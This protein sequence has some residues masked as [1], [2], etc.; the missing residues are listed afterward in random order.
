MKLLLPVISAACA[1]SLSFFPTCSQAA[2]LSHWKF[3]TQA[4]GIT[5][6]SV[7]SVNGTLVGGA[8]LVSGGV[9]G[10]ALSLANFVGTN[11]PAG[12][13]TTAQVQ[14]V[15]MGNNYEFANKPGGP[16]A[17][18]L[19]AWVKPITNGQVGHVAGSYE[20]PGDGGGY[21]MSTNFGGSSGSISGYTGSVGTQINATSISTEADH[22]YDLYDGEWHQLAL[23]FTGGLNPTASLWV[24][25]KL[26]KNGPN[27]AIGTGGIVGPDSF[28]EFVVGGYYFINRASIIGSYD[29]LIDDIQLYDTALGAQEIQLLYQNPGDNLNTIVVPEPNCLFLLGA[30]TVLFVIRRR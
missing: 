5:P 21:V 26:A 20:A 14:Y 8:S 22:S 10:N 29:G 1:A 12:F 3:D 23:G 15:S 30:G 4:G 9:S 17:F 7:G 24:D 11:Y 25:G 19:I 18:T 16:A 2:L 27:D 13:G 28:R 6:D